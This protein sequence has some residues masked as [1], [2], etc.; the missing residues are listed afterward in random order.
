MGRAVKAGID[1]FCI[2]LQFFTI[3]PIRK[4]F[5]LDKPRLKKA[6]QLYP[7]IGLFIGIVTVSLIFGLSALPMIPHSI[8]ALFILSVSIVLTGGLHLDGWMDASDA[9]FSY[10][11]K[12]KRLE[13]MDDPRTG[14]FAVLSVLFLLGWRYVL[15]FETLKIAS[16]TTLVLVVFLYYFSRLAMSYVFIFAKPAK[17]EGIAAFFKKGLERKDVLF[18]IVS[19]AV[20]FLI[21]VAI[22]GKAFVSVGILFMVSM[23]FAIWSKAFL[24]KQ[25]GGISGDTLGATLEGGETVLWLVVWLLHLFA[26]E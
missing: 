2:A 26:M 8:K 1:G 14:S 22:D 25:F 21:V 12:E 3:F 9:F 13:I 15:I 17:Q 18:H 4:Q 19:L 20:L 16:L 6:I 7:L 10:R 24:E 11:D 5:P 23:L